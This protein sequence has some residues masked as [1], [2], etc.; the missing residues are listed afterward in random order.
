MGT[1]LRVLV[2]EDSEDDTLLLLRELRRGGYET[3]HERVENP[4]EMEQALARGDWD[5]VIS[6][7]SMPSFSSIAALELL[8]GRGFADLPFII[9]SGQIGEDLAVTAMKAGAQDYIMKD[10]LARLTSAISRELDEAKVRRGRRRAEKALRESEERFRALVQNASDIIVILDADGTILY[11]SPAVERILGYSPE[12]RIGTNALDVLHPDDAEVV[13]ELFRKYL[14]EPGARPPMVEYR[15]RARDGTWRHLEAVSTNLL[16][17]PAVGGVVVNARDVT[18]RKRA[19]EELR[20]AEEK[21]RSIFENAV[22]GIYQATVD[23][24]LLT[25]NPAMARILGYDSPEDLM[26][27]VTDIAE[28]LYVDSGDREEFKRLMRSRGA[29]S[30]FETEMRRKDGKVVSVSFAARALHD[31]ST[32]EL[33]GYEGTMEDI[34]ERRRDEEALRE[35]RDAERRRIARDLHDEVLQDLTYSLQSM[36]LNR[37]KARQ[38]EVG[39]TDQEIEALRRAIGGLRNAIYDL[40]VESLRER[41]L[42]RAV[43]SLVEL[44]RRASEEWEVELIATGGLPDLPE[45]ARVEITR[46]VQEALVNARRHSEARR[47]EVILDAD[48]R[49]VRARVRDDGCGFDPER[50]WGMGITGMR[51]RAQDLG[52]D[53]EIRSEPGGGTEVSLRVP[54][55]FSGG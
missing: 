52:G 42:R 19:E 23:G 13:R 5:L 46:V 54:L 47:V 29:L 15:V 41:S 20:Q 22:E 36:Q 11:E 3:V 26:E 10:N 25:A 28:D 40:R 12:E 38:D 50:G 45:Q 37:Y 39:I 32:G 53:L 49:F 9:V 6:D 8:R 17:D 1:A 14:D 34:T 51:E 2:V 48:D 18:E 35:I 44:N 27:S 21:Y 43:E 55:S 24:R 31:P 4:E 30:G 33:V 7:H 16:H